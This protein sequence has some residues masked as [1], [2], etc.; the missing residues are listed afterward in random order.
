MLASATRHFGEHGY[1]DTSLERIAVDAGTTIR[2]VYHYFGNKRALFEAVNDALDAKLLEVLSDDA[3]AEGRDG[4]L[5]RFRA[6]LRIIAEPT[7]Q[8]VVLID[9]PAVLGR[10]RWSASPVSE[11]ASALLA[12]LPL[13]DDPIRAELVRRMMIGALTEA[14]VA[15]AE[16][17]TKREL[18]TR[19]EALIGIAA[20]ILPA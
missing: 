14:A 11:T 6:C 7:F 4:M 8:R 17:R 3:F 10:E 2:P 19:I 13:G 9:G 1:A 15:L 18:E 5:A 16:S 20:V 12:A